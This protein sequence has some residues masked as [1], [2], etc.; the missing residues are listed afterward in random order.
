MCSQTLDVKLLDCEV[1]LAW[2]KFLR[3]RSPILGLSCRRS[4]HPPTRPTLVG[5]EFGPRPHGN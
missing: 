2:V 4:A 5:G 3:P 1:A